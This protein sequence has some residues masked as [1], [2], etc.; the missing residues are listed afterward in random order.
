MKLILLLWL[1]EISVITF[2]ISIITF[3]ISRITFELSIVIFEISII[4]FEI[5]IITPYLDSK[6]GLFKKLLTIITG[7][8]CVLLNSA[9]E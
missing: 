2:E 3:E 8:N 7:K 9:Q 4:T 5:S 6:N 1:F